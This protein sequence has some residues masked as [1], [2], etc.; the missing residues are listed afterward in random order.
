M[1]FRIGDHDV[2]C[3]CALVD[4]PKRAIV[5]ELPPRGGRA[6][7]PAV[8]RGGRSRGWPRGD[9]EALGGLGGGDLHRARHP[10]A[11][12]PSR[13]EALRAMDAAGPDAPS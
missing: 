3:L 10:R 2:T 4:L 11:F 1:P 8:T 6:R 12:L 7:F 9:W 5:E 13:P